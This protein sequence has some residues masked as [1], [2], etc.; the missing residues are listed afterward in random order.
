MLASFD[1]SFS[2]PCHLLLSRQANFRPLTV[3]KQDFSCTTTI[4]QPRSTPEQVKPSI[5]ANQ[6]K[7][8]SGKD[9]LV[10]RLAIAMTTNSWLTRSLQSV[11][12]FLA[13]T[14]TI[15]ITTTR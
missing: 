14:N 4:Q 2:L 3:L 12:K 9:K 13:T 5:I 7:Q 10:C 15:I 8:D 1:P 6:I 11:Q